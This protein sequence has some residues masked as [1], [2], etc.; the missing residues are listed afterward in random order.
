MKKLAFLGLVAI[1]STLFSQSRDLEF[2]KG[3]NDAYEKNTGIRPMKEAASATAFTTI[4]WESQSYLA[5][6]VN[7]L[8]RGIGNYS[9]EKSGTNY[10]DGYW[11]AI[12]DLKDL[13]RNDKNTKKTE[14]VK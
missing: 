4:R 6:E 5:N 12:Q 13:S 14:K 11:K 3:Y 7:A 10:A 8:S 1:S 9:V 2:T